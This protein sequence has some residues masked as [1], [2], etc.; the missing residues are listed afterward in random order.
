MEDK[1]IILSFTKLSMY[2]D[3]GLKYKYKYF[4]K[5]PDKSNF[6]FILGDA[7][8]KALEYND[9]NI[10]TKKESF[11]ISKVIAFFEKVMKASL[12]E[13]KKKEGYVP[14]EEYQ[15]N[16]NLGKRMVEQYMI[17]LPNKKDYKPLVMEQQFQIKLPDADVHFRGFIDQ[18]TEDDIIVDRKTS[19]GMYQVLKDALGNPVIN[20]ET[21]NQ[22]FD[23]DQVKKLQLIMYALW[24]RATYG[25]KEKGLQY[26]IITKHKVPR[27]QVLDILITEKDVENAIDLMDRVTKQIRDEQFPAHISQGCGWCDFKDTC[28]AA[29]DA[30]ENPFTFY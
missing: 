2:L 1:E 5:T 22:I 10:I 15:K 13:F 4:D 12:K 19:K 6:N 3:C 24:F 23:G 28:T 18:I 20:P 14:D 7:V 25:R 16:L 21:G 11:P 30:R 8:H 29:K 17:N 27:V 26:D 9:N